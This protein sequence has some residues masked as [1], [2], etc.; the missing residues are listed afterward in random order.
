M[1]FENFGDFGESLADFVV[2]SLADLHRDESGHGIAQRGRIDVGSP[3][4]DH[5]AVRE[6]IEPGLHG[7]TGYAQSS[8]CFEHSYPWFGGEESQNTCIKLVNA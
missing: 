1:D 6:P 3:T 5:P 7:A 4:D 2:A 8:R